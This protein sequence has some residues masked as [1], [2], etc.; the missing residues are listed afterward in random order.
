MKSFCVEKPSNSSE[1]LLKKYGGELGYNRL[2]KLYRQKDVKVNGKRINKAVELARGDLVEVYYDGEPVRSKIKVVYRDENLLICDKPA[3]TSSEKFFERVRDEYST[4]MYTHRLDTNTRGIM[5]FA[6]NAHSYDELYSGLKERAFKKF[7]YCVVAGNPPK[8]RD[9]LTA[10]L[11][12]DEKKSEVKI[13]DDEVRGALPVVTGYEVVKR[14]EHSA[15]LRVELVT[16]RTHQIRAH[17]AHAGFFVLGDGKYGDERINR[18][19]GVKGQLLVSAEIAFAFNSGSV[20][21]YL[22][23]KSFSLDCSWLEKYLF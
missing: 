5:F 12:K 3:R 8:A 7:Y 9:T 14:G 1:Y 18:A 23:G 21:E 13:F 6:L 10:F 20:M 17:L 22:N 16:G 2:M 19:R 15:L 11:L 4:A